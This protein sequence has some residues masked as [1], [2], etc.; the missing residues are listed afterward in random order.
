MHYSK[1]KAGISG[2]IRELGF[3]DML[4]SLALA[5]AG[6]VWAIYFD[7]IIKDASRVGFV[8]T[9]FG[10]VGV[11][12]FIA[13]IPVIEKNSKTKILGLSLLL[14]AASYFLFSINNSMFFAILIGL[15]VYVSAAMRIN[16][17]GIILRDKSK[18]SAVSKNTGLIYT[19]LNSAWLFGP[20]LAGFV[21]SRFSVNLVFFISGV[22]MLLCWAFLKFSGFKDNRK[23]KEVDRHLIRFVKE[24]FSEKKFI[25]NY[26]VRGGISFW[27]AF[28][29]IFVPIYIITTKS[30]NGVLIVGYFLAGIVAPLIFLEY[31]FG[32]I[33]GRRG[34]KKM[35]FRGYLILAIVSILC[36]FV[37]EFYAI[38]LLLILGSVGA[39]MLEPTTDAYFFDITDR[40]QRDKYYG[41]Y[42]TSLDIFYA[43]SL[44]AVALVIKWFEFKY[45]FLVVGFFMV[46]FAL[47]SL[48][49]KKVIEEKPEIG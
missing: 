13:F 26:I 18:K 43:L 38:L 11:I 40:Y 8:N 22:L 12:S 28:I 20:L 45:S 10:I 6:T 1:H 27:W 36:F 47:I 5:S 48:G 14:Y 21:S 31:P 35:F 32:R 41:I 46:L 16:A 34:F 2:Q 17:M 42:N 23:E 4:S 25:L 37:N 30:V 19:L 15:F 24:F 39:A 3:I 49:V 7:S 29:Y 33:A 9:I 44:L